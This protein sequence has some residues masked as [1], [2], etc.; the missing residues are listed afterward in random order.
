MR[1][2]NQLLLQT[3]LFKKWNLVTMQNNGQCFDLCSLLAHTIG[4]E[5]RSAHVI[6]FIKNNKTEK[7]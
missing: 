5:V 4:R 6:R 1:L 7:T 2:E 3:A